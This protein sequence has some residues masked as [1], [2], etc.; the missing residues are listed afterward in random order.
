MLKGF[1]YMNNYCLFN[2]LAAMSFKVLFSQGVSLLVI[3]FFRNLTLLVLS[4]L[5]SYFSHLH[6]KCLRTPSKD[7]TASLDGG[8]IPLKVL[9]RR[10]I[11]A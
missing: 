10:F 6:K 7:A 1:L 3:A 11:L 4:S 2:N 5:L 8:S 9:D